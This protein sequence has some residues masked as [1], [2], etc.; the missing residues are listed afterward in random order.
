MPVMP[1]AASTT[2]DP[3]AR[4]AH[5]FAFSDVARIIG[6]AVVAGAAIGYLVAD[7][8]RET[9][10]NLAPIF[11]SAAVA[12]RRLMISAAGWGGHIDR[13]EARLDRIETTLAGQLDTELVG[14]NRGYLDCL[15][16]RTSRSR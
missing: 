3:T 13:V 14:Y 16:Q 5:L 4:S 12:A 15:K 6:A 8:D 1:E 11:A 7:Y 10:T 9:M 2:A